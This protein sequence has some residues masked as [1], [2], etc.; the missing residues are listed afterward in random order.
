[1]IFHTINDP[2]LT[3]FHRKLQIYPIINKKNDKGAEPWNGLAPLCWVNCAYGLL[4][5]I[6]SYDAIVAGVEGFHVVLN[7]LDGD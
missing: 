3:N 1:M 5:S 6:E 4:G 2:K 7:I